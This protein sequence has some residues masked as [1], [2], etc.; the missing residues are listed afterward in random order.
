[1]Q[2][3]LTPGF[4]KSWSLC[5]WVGGGGGGAGSWGKSKNNKR[6]SNQTD[7][8][9]FLKWDNH[10]VIT[11]IKQTIMTHNRSIIEKNKCKGNG[12]KP[13]QPNKIRN[14][15]STFCPKHQTG[16]ERKQLRRHKIKT[17]RAESQEDSSFL[18]DG[19]NAIL[20]KINAKI[21]LLFNLPI[22]TTSFKDWLIN[23]CQCKNNWLFRHIF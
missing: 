8:H 7:Q 5:L 1:M 3:P 21:K 10:N 2:Y 20:N 4:S 6:N 22:K 19:H 14:E 13:I 11:I 9:F 17:A 16:K 12:Q 23:S 15:N 18:A